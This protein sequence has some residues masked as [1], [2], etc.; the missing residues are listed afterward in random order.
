[1]AHY[2]MGIYGEPAV[3]KSV[4]S[5]GWEKPFFICTDENY[6]YLKCFG[7]KDE[8][9]IHITSWEEFKQLVKKFDFSKY[10]TIVVDLIE[11]LYQWCDA[12]YCKRNKIDDLSDVGYGKAYKIVRN[13][14]TYYILQLLNKKANV[15]LLSH[16]DETIGK[17]TKGVEFSEYS[18]SAYVPKKCWEMINGKLRF[19]F[20]A[21]IEEKQDNDGFTKKRCLSI[22]PKPHEFQINR[23]LDVDSLP[24]D[25][26]LS[27]NAFVD[28]FGKPNNVGEIEYKV[29]ENI[30][31]ATTDNTIK[32]EETI[33]K[34]E[35]KV[36]SS[37]VV[38]STKAVEPAVTIIKQP[39]VET[40]LVKTDS[41]NMSAQDK[42][43]SIKAKLNATKSAVVESTTKVE[44]P[45]PIKEPEKVVEP[46]KVENVSIATKTESQMSVAEKIA[47]IK[48]KLGK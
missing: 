25:I 27:Y 8:D 19:F 36:L 5:L 16:Q 42:I 35:P 7:A 34:E 44:E 43:A 41:V 39:K 40:T 6:D 10:E 13:D 3:G 18:P 17:T 37:K 30:K 9:H 15:I 45:K 31:P 20:R 1:M 38:E 21:Y 46:T 12:E 24:D 11:D 4:F 33:V 26:D 47:M 29:T 2:K 14:F 22:R 23:G 48:A 32:T 28:L